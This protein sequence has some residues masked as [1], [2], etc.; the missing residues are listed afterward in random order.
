MQLHGRRQLE[1][2]GIRGEHQSREDVVVDELVRTLVVAVR[3]VLYW[4]YSEE[5]E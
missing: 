1:L 5:V 2:Q 4:R 3:F